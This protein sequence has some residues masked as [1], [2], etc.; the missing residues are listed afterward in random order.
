LLLL[1]SFAICSCRAFVGFG[2][3]LCLWAVLQIV[4]AA[5][6]WSPP[7]FACYRH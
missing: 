5:A 6:L 2:C 1:L 7:V 4:E 3:T